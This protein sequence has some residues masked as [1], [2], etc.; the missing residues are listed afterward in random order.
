[1]EYRNPFGRRL[2]VLAW[3]GIIVGITLAL[4][5]NGI[6]T[7]D[8]GRFDESAIFWKFATGALADA[9]AAIG[10]TA[11]IAWTLLAGVE[12]RIAKQAELIEARDAMERARTHL[13]ERES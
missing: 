12:W 2:A 6:G 10:I 5:G 4:I 9:S 3:V 8:S 7:I 1:M 11:A 13:R